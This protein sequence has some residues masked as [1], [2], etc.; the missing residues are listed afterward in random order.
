MNC[1]S[2]KNTN[3]ILLIC[4]VCCRKQIRCKYKLQVY[5]FFNLFFSERHT[6][7]PFV[8]M[9][10]VL[11]RSWLPPLLGGEISLDIT[12]SIVSVGVSLS[13]STTTNDSNL[14]CTQTM[15]FQDTKNWQNL[16]GNPRWQ[17]FA[18][19]H[20]FNACTN[21]KLDYA[22][23]MSNRLPICIYLYPSWSSLHWLMLNKHKHD[24]WTQQLKTLI[25]QF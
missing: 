23:F 20:T 25:D 11:A 14:K 2:L 13:N 19:I 12:Q 17:H 5:S 9:F 4:L 24:S 3:I 8:L 22:F 10:V 18:C 15:Q 21:S 16:P 7:F 6:C 1:H